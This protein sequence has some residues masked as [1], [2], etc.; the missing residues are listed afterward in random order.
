MYNA[1][2][3]QLYTLPDNQKAATI[4]AVN[5]N[6]RSITINTLRR[7][8]F[9]FAMKEKEMAGFL[10]PEQRPD[11]FSQNGYFLAP[12]PTYNNAIRSINDTFPEGSRKVK[13]SNTSYTV[14]IPKHQNSLNS[15]DG[16]ITRSIN[17]TLVYIPLHPNS[18]N[19]SHN[20]GDVGD[21]TD[22]DIS[23]RNTRRRRPS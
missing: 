1:Y 20:Y 8:G 18:P 10:P 5:K 4:R 21:T 13:H 23:P 2:T 15:G 12:F 6:S 16:D 22:G 19:N 7:N 9:T 17:D 11:W 3:V 14:Y